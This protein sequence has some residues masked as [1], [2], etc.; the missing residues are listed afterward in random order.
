MAH[1]VFPVSVKLRKG[2]EIV[3]KDEEYTRVNFDKLKSLKAVFKK[4]SSF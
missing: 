4:G 3:D 2:V 1:E